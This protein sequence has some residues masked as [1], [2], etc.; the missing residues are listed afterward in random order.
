MGRDFHLYII[1]NTGNEKLKELIRSIYD[2][3]EIS[4]ILFSYEKRREEAIDEHL[5]IIR[6]LK[7][8]NGEKSQAAM[9]EHIRNSFNMITNI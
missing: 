3:L 8:R 9:E 4:R 7:E 2:Q 5:E 1:E 6:A